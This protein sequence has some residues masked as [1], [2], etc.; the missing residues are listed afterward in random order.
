[1]PAEEAAGLSRLSRYIFREVANFP[2]GLQLPDLSVRLDI[3]H[4]IGAIPITSPALM[5]GVEPVDAAYNAGTQH[6]EGSRVRNR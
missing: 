5:I 1:M 6:P 2:E 3:F 4:L